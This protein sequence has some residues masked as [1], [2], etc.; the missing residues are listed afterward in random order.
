MNK[1]FTVIGNWKMHKTAREAVD[2]LEI[3]M[4]QVRGCQVN[5]FI[6]APCLLIGSAVQGVK[7]SSVRIGAQN[8]HE[9]REGAFTGEVSGVMLKEAGA[10]FVILGHSERRELFGE[11]D[12]R[13][14]KKVHRALGCDLTPVLCVGESLEAREAGKT[15][16]VL[17]K[18]LHSSLRHLPQEAFKNL[19]IAYE[20]LWAIGVGLSARGDVAQE[21]HAWIRK[22]LERLCGKMAA[23]LPILYGGSVKKENA[24]ELSSQRDIDGLLV[25]GASLEASSFVSIINQLNWQKKT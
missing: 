7:N 24:K 25:G 14:E 5:I 11:T 8:M 12:E 18:Q 3:L 20:P 21:A 9:E 16:E 19:M 2:F 15:E 10:S 4:P 22:C 1:S 13:I 6:A 17:Q 23:S